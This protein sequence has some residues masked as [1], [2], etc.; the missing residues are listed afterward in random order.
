MSLRTNLLKVIEHARALTGPTGFDIRI[1]Q[2]TI[3]TRTWSGSILRQGVATDSDLIIPAIYPIRLITEQELNSAGGQYEVG[4][5]LVD[6][7]TPTD[8]AGV[9]YTPTQLRPVVTS[10]NVEV[11]YVITGPHSGEYD[12]IDLRTYR[13]FTWQIVLRRKITIP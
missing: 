3:R 10:D 6:H 8:G 12:L 5:I 2:L 11:I 4:D 9:G 7:I 1:N 13:P